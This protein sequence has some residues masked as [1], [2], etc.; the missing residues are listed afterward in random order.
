MRHRYPWIAE[1]LANQI[2]YLMRNGTAAIQSRGRKLL[3][4]LE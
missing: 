3:L 1:E 2:R 4:Q